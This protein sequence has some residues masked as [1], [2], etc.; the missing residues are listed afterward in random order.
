MN[1]KLSNYF[2]EQSSNLLNFLVSDYSFNKPKISIDNRTW[3]TTVTFMGK[4]IAFECILD[5]RESDVSCKIAKV[6]DGQKT[7]YYAV[8]EKRERVRDE[9]VSILRRKGVRS[10]LLTKLDKKMKIEEIVHTVLSDYARMIREYTDTL[11]N[12]PDNIFDP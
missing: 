7:K 10:K 6:I 3:F 5:P 12:N 4:D 1:S 2:F 11:L 8:N 9:I